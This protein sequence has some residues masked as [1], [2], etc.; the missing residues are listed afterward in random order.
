[1]KKTPSDTID[2]LDVAIP[3]H[4]D[5]DEYTISCHMNW[6]MSNWECIYGRGCP[7]LFG[8]QDSTHPDDTGCCV[9]S[10]Y[11]ADKDDYKRVEARMKELTDEDWDVELRR[12]VEKHGWARIFNDDPDE[13]N[14]KGKVFE[15]GCVF[16]NRNGGSAG[17]PGCAFVQMS[18]RIGG[19]HIDVM[20]T[21]C[22][23]LP[24][25]FNDINDDGAYM[26]L[27]PWDIEEWGE[28]DETGTMDWHCSWWCVDA[29]DAYIGEGVVW[30][31]MEREIRR[32]IGDFEY[33]IIDKAIRERL[34]RGH[35][36]DNMPGASLN[37]GRPLIPL[38]IGNRKPRREPSP[39]P[40]I[41]ARLKEANDAAGA[42]AD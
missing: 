5:N 24:L 15:R 17:K 36:Y 21:V 31:T 26:T 23:Q 40:E 1:V 9:D 3:A 10:F 30:K 41:L 14:G 2:W 37:G 6:L 20:P 18:K 25:R 22:W 42:D 29:P 32:T 4:G 7:G 35:L 38:M 19:D 11:F 13:F 12:H 34:E 33:D 8:I 28:T 16:Q 27:G 39:Y